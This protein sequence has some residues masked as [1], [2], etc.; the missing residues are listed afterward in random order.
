MRFEEFEVT[1]VRRGHDTR[2][3]FWGF[4]TYPRECDFSVKHG[5]GKYVSPME[6]ALKVAAQWCTICCR[7]KDCVH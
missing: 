5:I 7:P 4:V 2:E 3:S 1:R 6:T